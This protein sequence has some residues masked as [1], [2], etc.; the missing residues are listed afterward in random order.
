M[1][2]MQCD[3]SFL[4]NYTSDQHTSTFGRT[5]PFWAG[6][7][8]CSGSFDVLWRVW[9]ATPLLFMRWPVCVFN[10]AT[11]GAATRRPFIMKSQTSVQDLSVAGY[12]MLSAFYISF[13]HLYLISSLALNNFFL[14]LKFLLFTSRFG[15]L[16]WRMNIPQIPFTI[17]H[18]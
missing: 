11:G 16:H 12:I 8:D 2:V 10:A 1:N 5:V 3:N 6:L 15:Y 9:L 7:Q 13:F 14:T 18:M 4:N 17:I